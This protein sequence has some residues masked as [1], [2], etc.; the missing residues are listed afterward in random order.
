MILVSVGVD[1]WVGAALLCAL[2]ALAL[3]APWFLHARVTVDRRSAVI[4]FAKT[5]LAEIESDFQCGAISSEEYHQLTLEQQRRLLQEADVGVTNL[6]HN[7]GRIWLLVFAVS[8]PIFAG[9]FYF[10]SGSWADWRIQQ[11]LEQSEREVQAGSDNRDTLEALR[12]ALERSLAQH[13]D[14]DGRRRFM[15]AQLDMEF[16]RYGAAAEQFGLILRKFPEDASIAAQYAQALYLASNR[17]LTPEVMAQ[18]QRALQLDPNQ[19]TALGLLGIAAFERKDFAQALLHWRHLLRM[20][21]PNAPGRAMIERGIKEA[22][23]QLGPK[24]FPGPKFVVSVS[25]ANTLASAR[26][27]GGTLFVFAKAVAG[28]PMPLAVARLDASKLPIEVTLDD[29]MAMAP[30]M[31][32][33]SARQVQ[34]FARITASGQVRGEP[35]DLEGSSAPIMVSDTEQKVALTIDRKL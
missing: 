17:Q 21:S 16:Q 31:D 22:E 33:S 13:D 30:G 11:L 34:I 5:R 32:L 35:G 6:V 23:Q 29:S 27:V 2:T 19:T 1:F 3:L 10:Y 28:P 18:A 14:S 8:A 4:D 15:L 9:A 7:R 26:P 20:L 25:I 24:G 12:N